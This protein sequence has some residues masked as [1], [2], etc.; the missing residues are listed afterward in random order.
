MCTFLQQY[1]GV[2]VNLP[3]TF[4]LMPAAA[5]TIVK[6]ATFVAHD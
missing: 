1:F 5:N 2:D 3:E 4:Q 6:L